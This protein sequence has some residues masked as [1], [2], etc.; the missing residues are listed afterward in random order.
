MSP[1]RLRFASD[2]DQLRGISRTIDAVADEY[3]R[4]RNGGGRFLINERGRFARR[5]ESQKSNSYALK[6]QIE[7]LESLSHYPWLGSGALLG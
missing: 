2:R 7:L 4:V 1:S 5:R 6:S 3:V